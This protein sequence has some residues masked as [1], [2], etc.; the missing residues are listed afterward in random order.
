LRSFDTIYFVALFLC[1]EY[2]PIWIR[3]LTPYTNILGIKEGMVYALV[4][5][6]EARTGT[7][8]GFY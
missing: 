8:L 4:F 1:F 5:L 6:L 7:K 2:E 3:K